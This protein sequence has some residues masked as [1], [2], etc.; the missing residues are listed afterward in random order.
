MAAPDKMETMTMTTAQFK[1]KLESLD[2]DDLEGYSE[3]IDEFGEPRLETYC[4]LYADYTVGYQ[5]D[6]DDQCFRAV[7][8]I[9][10]GKPLSEAQVLIDLEHPGGAGARAILADLYAQWSTPA[11]A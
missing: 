11:P 1:D 10:H 5:N 3:V 9:M 4:N 8:G 2:R 7:H 6:L